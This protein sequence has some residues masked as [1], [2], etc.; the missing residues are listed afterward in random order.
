MRADLTDP[1]N[2]SACCNNSSPTPSPTL[3]GFEEAVDEFK[4]RVPDL[5]RGLVEKIQEAHKQTSNSRRHF[6][7]FFEL[8]PERLNPKFPRGGR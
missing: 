3:K 2:L 8:M 1:R 5:A 6:K 4:E 7:K